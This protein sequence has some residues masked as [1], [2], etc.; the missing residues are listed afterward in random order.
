LDANAL[1]DL[2]LGWGALTNLATLSLR[3]N[4]VTRLPPSLTA[5]KNLTSV[6][7]ESNEVRYAPLCLFALPRLAVLVLAANKLEQ[8]KTF[9]E[10]RSEGGGASDNLKGLL[11]ARAGGDV[12][13]GRRQAQR[14]WLLIKQ[15]VF[16]AAAK[17]A[18]SLRFELTALATLDLSRN[19]IFILPTHITRMV[20]L[21]DLNLAHNRLSHLPPTLSRLARLRRLDLSQNLFLELPAPVCSLPSLQALNLRANK[22]YTLPPAVASLPPL[23]ELDLR[24][25]FIS[26]L[27]PQFA[28]LA[29]SARV[30][31]VEGNPLSAILADN[32]AADTPPLLLT[33]AQ[34]RVDA[35]HRLVVASTAGG[36]AALTGALRFVNLGLQDYPSA[37]VDAARVVSLDLTKNLLAQLPPYLSLMR[38]LRSMRVAHNRLKSLGFGMRALTE[39]EELD[40]S[41][42]ALKYIDSGVTALVRLKDLNVSFNLMESWDL[43]IRNMKALR[44]L[45]ACGNPLLKI[46]T[47]CVRHPS[48]AALSLASGQLRG[49]DAR[50]QYLLGAT[51]IDVS[52]NFINYLSDEA[53][54]HWRK[55]TNLNLSRNSLTTL[56]PTL[57]AV[58]ALEVRL[59][60][61]SL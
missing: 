14:R 13:E 40:A 12:S 30:V 43:R 50:L 6:D 1:R 33:P 37:T 28:P 24:D 21:C 32:S 47:G 23:E 17:G 35:L 10:I 53:C 36:A 57:S 49:V 15:S 2:P 61:P 45:N 31:R 44:A 46:S 52:N 5:L 8:F 41:F 42:N 25:N 22:I 7:L 26:T 48:L 4:V 3:A 29:F 9:E 18:F 19:S 56:P 58:A 38:R 16:A 51:S 59:N 20:A 27:P 55:L 39:L 11:L 60:F 34:A 54:L